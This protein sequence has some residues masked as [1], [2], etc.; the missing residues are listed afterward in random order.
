M[1]NTE[2]PVALITGAAAGLG[3]GLAEYFFLQGYQ[4]FLV[5]R[6]AQA[7]NDKVALLAGSASSDAQKV[8]AHCVDLIAPESEPIEQL[9]VNFHA[10]FSELAVLVNNAGITHRS[11]AQNTDIAVT[12]RVLA[13]DFLVPVEL[14]QALL[15]ALLRYGNA[16][17][18]AIILNIGS[19]AGWMPV[20]ARSGYCA[21]KSALHQYFETL[22]AELAQ[23]P[24]HILMVYPSF[25]A[26]DI[27][28]NALSGN[29][30]PAQHARSTIGDVHS[31]DWMV[32]RIAKALRR[33][34]ARLFP[35]RSIALASIFYRLWPTLFLT[36]MRKK[37]AQEWQVGELNK[38][39][40]QAGG[41]Q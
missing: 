33:R 13:L 1:T 11:L 39:S 41:T 40:V 12:R 19:M 20:V 17:R 8:V 4:L 21:A 2:K 18:S 15:P 31:V 10:H 30:Q 37:F 14:T 36:L 9:V 26:T 25:L 38:P 24:V 6:D 5:D 32:V 29:G 27:E 22:R 3:W 16:H 28:K 23:Q 35:N 7:L 34:R